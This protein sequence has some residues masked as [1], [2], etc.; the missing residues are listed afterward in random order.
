VACKSQVSGS[1]PFW[2]KSFF[3]FLFQSLLLFQ[4]FLAAEKFILDNN[5]NYNWQKIFGI[6]QFIV[7]K[8]ISDEMPVDHQFL[9]I[10]H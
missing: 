5:M 2:V 8:P 4:C 6:R 7:I 3:S 10:F 1:N 9:F